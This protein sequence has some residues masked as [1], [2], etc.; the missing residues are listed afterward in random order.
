M[1]KIREEC[2][3]CKGTGLYR[4]LCESPGQ[5]VV[6][7]YCEGQ[8]WITHSYNEFI[9]RKKR[10]NIKSIFLDGGTFGGNK[11]KTSMSYKEFEAA[12]PVAYPI[13]VKKVETK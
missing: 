6:C 2:P 9:G 8:G 12:Y 5:A 13:K 11:P 7:L 1:P 4:G 3:S 10:R